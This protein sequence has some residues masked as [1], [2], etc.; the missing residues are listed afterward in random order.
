MSAIFDAWSGY[1]ASRI[2]IFLGFPKQR[3]GTHLNCHT[4]ARPIPTIGVCHPDG[5]G[6]FFQPI[7]C[8][9][10]KKILCSDI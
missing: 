10:K 3:V 4:S 9:G 6:I 1:L 8:D 5:W 7:A 2:A